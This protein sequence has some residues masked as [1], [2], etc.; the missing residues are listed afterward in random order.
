V[1][2]HVSL[3]FV[4]VYPVLMVGYSFKSSSVGYICNHLKLYILSRMSQLQDSWIP[5]LCIS[6]VMFL[7]CISWN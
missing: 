7:K 5:K 2:P 6:Y 3:I 4:M 1:K